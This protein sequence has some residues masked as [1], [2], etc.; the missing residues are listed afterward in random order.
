MTRWVLGRLLAPL[1]TSKRATSYRPAKEHDSGTVLFY[2]AEEESSL[3]GRYSVAPA[4]Q[5]FYLLGSGRNACPPRTTCPRRASSKQP[6]MV[7]NLPRGHWFA[8]TGNLLGVDL[9]LARGMRG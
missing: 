6:P 5:G 3:A 9:R 7:N 1:P 2:P 8:I 4:G